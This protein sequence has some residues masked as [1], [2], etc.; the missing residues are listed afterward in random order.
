MTTGR[1][2]G[3]SGPEPIYVVEPVIDKAA[4]ELALDA[5]ELRRRNTI[6]KSAM[7]Y[8]T[9]L[10]QTYDSGDFAKNLG[11]ALHLAAYDGIA[12]RRAGARPRRQ[13]LR[14]ARATPGAA[15][16]GAPCDA[17]PGPLSPPPR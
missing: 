10:H 8:T 9:P 15:T 11:D 12:E 5:A 13:P 1:Y 2:G 17:A 16:P 4:R 6:S 7:P 3:G 14:P